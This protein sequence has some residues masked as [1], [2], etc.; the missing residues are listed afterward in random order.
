VNFIEHL[1]EQRAFSWRTFGPGDRTNMV[2]DHIRKELVEIENEPDA[3]EEWIDVVLLACDGAWRQGY[4]PEEIAAALAAKL[5]KN[6]A[7]KWPDWRKADPGK[8]IE[9][10]R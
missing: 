7:R 6:K 3:L 2:L 9:H 5:E 8:A 4:Q 1:R 10:V